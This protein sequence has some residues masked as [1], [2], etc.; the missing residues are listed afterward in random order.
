LGGTKN[1]LT[2]QRGTSSKKGWEPLSR[3]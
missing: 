2:W 3:L 1:A